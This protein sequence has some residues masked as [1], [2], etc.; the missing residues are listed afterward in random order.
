M[1]RVRSSACRLRAFARAAFS[2]LD[3]IPPII[4][5]HRHICLKHFG[6]TAGGDSLSRLQWILTQTMHVVRSGGSS[7]RTLA[8]P[9]FTLPSGGE[10]HEFRLRAAII[11]QQINENK[12]RVFGIRVL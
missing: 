9:V 11:I 2:S 7:S 4:V 5:N 12:P 8:L 1:P 6:P 3:K 10:H